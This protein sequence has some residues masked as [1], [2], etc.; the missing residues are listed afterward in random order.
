MA[1]KA[2][3]PIDP[4]WST[5]GNGFNVPKP[6]GGARQHSIILFCGDVVSESEPNYGRRQ[7]DPEYFL[8]VVTP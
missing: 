1:S 7:Y 2:I 5:E 3:W 6:R 8:Y 4:Q